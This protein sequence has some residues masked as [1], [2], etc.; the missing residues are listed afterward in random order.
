MRYRPRPP[1]GPA[2]DSAVG[3]IERLLGEAA[4]RHPAGVW[5][6]RAQHVLMICACVTLHGSPD[7]IVFDTVDGLGWRRWPDDLPDEEMVRAP[8]EAG[9][10]A[11]PSDV[12]A[13]LRGDAADPWTSGDGHG[14][15]EVA[16]A[17]RRWMVDD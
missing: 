1:S 6:G 4:S 11:D 3:G 15:P 10:H 16:G 7:W 13:W 17:L 14:D 8:R 12:L 9:G 2:A 5:Q